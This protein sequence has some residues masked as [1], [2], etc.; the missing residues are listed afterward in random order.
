MKTGLDDRSRPNVPSDMTRAKLRLKRIRLDRLRAAVEA[1]SHISCE[2]DLQVCFQLCEAILAKLILGS[3]W[4]GCA[5]SMRSFGR[6]D[7]TMLSFVAMPY[8]DRKSVV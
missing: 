3:V 5:N 8:R 7:L 2:D 6:T 1:L 4:D